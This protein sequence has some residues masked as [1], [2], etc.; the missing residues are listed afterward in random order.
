MRKS[1]HLFLPRRLLQNDAFHFRLTLDEMSG[2]GTV[3]TS[4]KCQ[5]S[6][7][8][9]QS[10]CQSQWRHA[11][12]SW[13]ARIHVEEMYYFPHFS[14]LRNWWT[15]TVCKI[16]GKD[17]N[18]LKT[19]FH[20]IN[21]LS[22]RSVSTWDSQAVSRSDETVI[23]GNLVIAGRQRDQASI[24]GWNAAGLEKRMWSNIH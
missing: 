20:T 2:L 23:L 17:L 10:C 9:C 19:R 11:I 12:I 18:G 4:P 22:A 5:S 13:L 3:C 16:P 24:C 7:P 21:H 6:S 8:K 1:W 15:N 14:N